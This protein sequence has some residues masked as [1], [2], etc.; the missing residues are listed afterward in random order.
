MEK[1][2]AIFAI[3][4]FLIIGLS[5]LFQH[6]AWKEFFLVLSAQGRTGAFANGFL[7]LISGSIIVSF[8]NVWTGVPVILTLIG[9]AFLLKSVVVFLNPDWGVRSMAG[10]QHASELKFRV[11]GLCFLGIAL[12]LALCI[13]FQAY[14]PTV[15]L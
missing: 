4:N 14:P 9:W 13:A 1:S 3:I 5:H 6:Q 11:A 12:I 7:T 2:I 10:V 15:G 8:H